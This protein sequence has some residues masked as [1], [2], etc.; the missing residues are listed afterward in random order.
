MTEQLA[1]SILQFCSLHGI[2]RSSFYNL[3]KAGRGP[4]TM[5]VYGRVLISREAAEAW[6]RQCEASGPAEAA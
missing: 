3:V 5:T 4:R 6:R 1:Y 2:S